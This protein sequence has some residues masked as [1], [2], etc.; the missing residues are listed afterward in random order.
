MGRWLGVGRLGSE[1]GGEQGGLWAEAGEGREKEPGKGVTGRSTHQ[2]CPRVVILW[3]RC[4]T[5]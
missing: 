2:L 5:T 4:L 1:R 3:S